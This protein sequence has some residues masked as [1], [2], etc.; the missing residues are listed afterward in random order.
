MSNFWWAGGKVCVVRSPES[1]V[2]K[3]ERKKKGKKLSKSKAAEKS[4]EKRG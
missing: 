3:R 4:E 2:N 1:L